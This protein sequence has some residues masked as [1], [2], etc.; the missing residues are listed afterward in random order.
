MGITRFDSGTEP[1]VRRV[2]A[3]GTASLKIFLAYKGAF[4]IDDAELYQTL[5]LAKRLG[6]IVT[7]HCEN[8]EI[9]ARLQQRL[10]AEG[11]TGPEWHLSLIHI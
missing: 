6:L 4:G 9:V 2:A 11:K 8:A 5:D 7:A 1:M 10:L 3:D